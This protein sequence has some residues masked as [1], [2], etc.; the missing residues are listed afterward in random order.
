MKKYLIIIFLFIVHTSVSQN[1]YICKNGEASFFSKSLIENIDG[2]SKSM[3]SILNTSTGE[4][5]FVV[6]MTSFKFKKALMEEHFNEKYVESDKYPYGAYKGMI[7]EKINYSA[8]GKFSITST[9]ILTIHGVKKERTDSGTLVI[10]DGNISMQ[11]EFNVALKDFNIKVPKLLIDNVA[12]S[13]NV[14]CNAVFTLYK[15]DK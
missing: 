12:D 3:S 1:I 6:P 5:V 14:K 13:V 15:K 7:N 11:S 2:K 4:I 9:G 10:K 8:D